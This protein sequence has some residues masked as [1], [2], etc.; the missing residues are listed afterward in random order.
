MNKNYVI[1][2][3]TCSEAIDLEKDHDKNVTVW[4]ILKWILETGDNVY[5]DILN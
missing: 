1:I 3:H 4:C 5:K 2:T